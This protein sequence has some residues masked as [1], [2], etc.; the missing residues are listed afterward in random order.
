[1]LLKKSYGMVTLKPVQKMALW[2]MTLE[3]ESSLVARALAACGGR[4]ATPT[5]Q[6]R[7]LL[8]GRCPDSQLESGVT[9]NSMLV[10]LS[11]VFILFP[12]HQS[13]ISNFFFLESKVI[14]PRLSQDHGQKNTDLHSSS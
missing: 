2:Q 9:Q 13:Y 11:T 14:H 8:L 5:L 10:R 3:A 7:R 1:M 12:M 4:L 6:P